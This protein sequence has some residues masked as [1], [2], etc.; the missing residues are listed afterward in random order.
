MPLNITVV[1]GHVFADG[2]LVVTASLNALGQPVI[3]ITGSV[4][5]SEIAAGGVNVTHVQ[6]GAFFNAVASGAANAYVVTLAPAPAALADG[7]WFSF[8]ANQANTGPVTVNVNG[9]GAKALVTPAREAL[10]GGE[11]TNGQEVWVQYDGSQF[12]MVSP[13]SIPTAFYAVDSGVANAYV[14]TLA[15]VSVSALA[16]LTGIPIT[17]KSSAACTGAST[18]AVNGLAATAITKKGATT[19]SANDIQTG[20][21]VT[22]VYD[23]TQFQIVGAM[24]APALPSVGAA[25]AYQY[26]RAMTVDSAGRVTAMT[27]GVN[28]TTAAVPAKGSAVTFTHGL[29]AKPTFVRVVAVMGST[30]EHGYTAGDEKEIKDIIADWDG[31][32]SDAYAF[33]VKATATAVVVTRVNSAGSE[34]ICNDA[35]SALRQ[36]WTASLWTLRVYAF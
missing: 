12:Q 18:L 24:D 29:G 4:G 26:P 13:R 31:T 11:I 3:T 9:L 28:N 7:L 19:L 20:H 16:Q 34:W 10:V 36:A 35:G 33:Q 14:V 5:G 30:T 27:A 15:G 21:A 1:P 22:V 23:G 17:F 25:G 8:R 32:E 6:A 2:E